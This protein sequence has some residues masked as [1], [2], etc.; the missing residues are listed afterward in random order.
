MALR[1]ARLED[2]LHDPLVQLQR[3]T[4]QSILDVKDYFIRYFTK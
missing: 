1:P 3:R 4:G 2:S